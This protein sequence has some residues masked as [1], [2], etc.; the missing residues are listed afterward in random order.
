M[1]PARLSLI[2][3]LSLTTFC[4]D[5]LG[6]V[7]R[8]DIVSRELVANGQT[9]GAA[10]S[11]EKL[12][13]RVDFTLDPI[14]PANG[15]VVDLDKAPVKS[16]GRVYYSADLYILKPTVQ[17][18]ANNTLLVE[19]PNRGDKAIIP[20]FNRGAVGSPDPTAPSHFG[21]GFLMRHGF[22]LAWV[23][24]QFDVPRRDALLR[25]YPVF[26]T[27]TV[28]G[29]PVVGRVRSDHVFSRNTRVFP[30]GDR[31]HW[32]YPV[33]DAHD[34]RNVLT[35]RGER[36]GIRR[37]IPRAK[38]RFG[39]IVNG[40]PVADSQHIYMEDGFRKG[41]IYEAVY[42][43]KNPAVVGLGLTA[44]RDLVS[45]LKHDHRTPTPVKQV[46]AMGISQTGRFLR[47][48]LY[49]GFN[50]DLNGERVFDGVIVHTAGA[51]RGSFNHRFAQPSRDGHPFS[52]FFYPTDIFPFSGLPQRDAK[53]DRTDGLLN[54]LT[55]S[56]ALPK[57][58]LTN[59]GYEYWGRAASLIHTTIDGKDDQ[60]LHPNTRVYHFAGTQ[61]FVGRFPP[62]PEGTRY[63][64]NPLNF[65]WSLR[66]LL[67][68]M[69]AWVE[70]GTAPPPSRYPRI[71]DGTLIR[72]DELRYPSI[73]NF[74]PTIK[75]HSAYRADYGP[76]FLSHGVVDVTP[77]VLEGAYP[78][79]VSQVDV[80]GNEVAGVRL[81]EIAAPL[82]TYTPWNWRS[83]EIGAASELAD[84]RGGFF[85][86]PRTRAEKA[87][88]GDSRL[89]VQER[90]VDK[91]DYLKRYRKAAMRLV[92]ERLLLEEDLDEMENHAAVLWEVVHRH[93]PT[94]KRGDLAEARRSEP[95]DA[96]G[97]KVQ[98]ARDWP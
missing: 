75:A 47:H 42:V 73:P 62:K 43:A 36:H 28:D 35:V 66:A 69:K 15:R 78:V 96:I 23:G 46:L 61:H 51:G 89:S 54:V 82:A 4:N 93:E 95:S 87:S 86:F 97:A 76:R 81:P 27:R 13:A 29:A 11:Y 16:D 32:A 85:P 20:Y 63:P 64:V 33:A 52:A 22:T 10:G 7:E 59:S 88:T 72:P 8:I 3:L 58:F 26:V 67:L 45:Y 34:P 70:H 68:G 9:F 14:H 39:N 37:T 40:R 18:K 25:L 49:Q 12:R 30:L 77:P 2:A 38:W 80:D 6:E 71:A 48:F 84:F 21:D 1:T 98:A 65:L 74:E 55:G 19:I 24:W 60:A 83:S 17:S 92:R 53:L 44:V 57:I 90:Y 31:D 41:K 94:S 5:A 56:K 91:A 79:L 50:A